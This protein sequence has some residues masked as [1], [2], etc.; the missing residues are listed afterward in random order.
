M[1]PLLRVCRVAIK[2]LH[3]ELGD[4][5]RHKH[6]F[7][8]EAKNASALM[9]RN[10]VHTQDF[11]EVDGLY[12]LVMEYVEGL[13]AREMMRQAH[14]HNLPIPPHVIAEVG[15]QICDG[16]HHA[17]SASDTQGRPMGLVHCDVK[18]CNVIL[19]NHG[20]V[21]VLDFGVSKTVFEE[22]KKGFFVEHGD[23]WLPSRSI[24]VKWFLEQISMRW[25]SYFYEM[26]ASKQM[27]SRKEKKD[28]EEDPSA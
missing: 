28:P 19:N 22:Q 7:I 5:E 10:I 15:R 3:P 17:H 16:L 11:E 13:T 4:Q 6:L 1:K 26:A 24:K 12:L 2:M 18:P 8:Q 9:H 14:Q 21:K 23:T 20:A 27:F 25:R